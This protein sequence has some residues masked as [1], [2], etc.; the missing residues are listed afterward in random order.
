[1]LV[2]LRLVGAMGEEFGYHHQYEVSDAK[3]IFRALASNFK[4]FRNFVTA[5]EDAGIGYQVLMDKV[6]S[7]YEDLKEAIAPQ[8]MVISPVVVGK[9]GV[10]KIIAGIAIIALAAFVPFSIGLL[11]A[12]VISGA[13][14]G[15]AILLSGISQV[16]AEG[17]TSSKNQSTTIGTTGTINQGDPI[18]LGYGRI[19]ARGRIISAGTTISRR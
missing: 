16:L 19:F 12:G 15:A 2:N 17:K 4:E 9:G 11:G 18:P 3:E 14:I 8:F 5:S 10:G 7:T 13:S 1:M 6:E